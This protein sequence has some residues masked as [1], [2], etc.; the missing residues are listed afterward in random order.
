MKPR[1]LSIL[2]KPNFIQYSSVITSQHSCC[3][4]INPNHPKSCKSQLLA[5]CPCYPST[6]HSPYSRRVIS[7]HKLY[8]VALLL[9]MASLCTQNKIQ[10]PY[11]DLQNFPSSHHLLSCSFR[12]RA[13]GLTVSCLEQPFPLHLYW[14]KCQP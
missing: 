13:F 4:Y 8:H 5:Y 7:K 9:F 12:S 6:N 3:Q 1:S 10:T 2:L 14:L 11:E